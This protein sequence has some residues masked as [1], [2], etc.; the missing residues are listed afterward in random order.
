MTHPPVAPP[1]PASPPPRSSGGQQLVRATEGAHP[2]GGDLSLFFIWVQTAAGMV[3]RCE[4]VSRQHQVGRQLLV[5]RGT[6][7]C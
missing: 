6:T 4:F 7:L 5:M 2:R 3:A 1:P